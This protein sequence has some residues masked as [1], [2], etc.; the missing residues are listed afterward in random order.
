MKMN[1]ITNQ[2]LYLIEPVL[3]FNN[4]IALTC[5]FAGYKNEKNFNQWK[6]KRGDQSIFRRWSKTIRSRYSNLYSRKI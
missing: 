1:V 6:S 4:F 3:N 2:K 5:L